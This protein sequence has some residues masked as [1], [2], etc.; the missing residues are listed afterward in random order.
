MEN[1]YNKLTRFRLEASVQDVNESGKEYLA[2]ELRQLLE[3]NKTYQSKTD[4]LGYSISSID[5]KIALLDEE[6][7]DIRNYKNRL[8]VAKE[9]ALSVGAKVFSEYG[10]FKIEGATITS[11][12][13][14]GGS[15]KSKLEVEVSDEAA[16]I[17]Q[18]YYIKVLDEKRIIEDYQNGDFKEFIEQ[19]AKVKEVVTVIPSKLRVNKRRAKNNDEYIGDISNQ[20]IS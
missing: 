14:I 19:Y 13:V 7:K 4:Y 15:T 12:T 1:K 18:G 20:E 5:E 6:M 9:I 11:I 2:S 3:S 17:D 10:I 8:K 16:L